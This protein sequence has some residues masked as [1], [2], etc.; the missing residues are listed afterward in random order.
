VVIPA[1]INEV[2]VIEVVIIVRGDLEVVLGRYDGMVSRYL[3]VSGLRF[4][5]SLG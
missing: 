3:L 5:L 2:V 1:S 4:L